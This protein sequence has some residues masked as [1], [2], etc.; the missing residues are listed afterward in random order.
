ML[1]RAPLICGSNA[2][3]ELC[4]CVDRLLL[5]PKA[6]V[7]LCGEIFCR[8]LAEAAAHGKQKVATRPETV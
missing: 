3:V 5:L 8:A 2:C 6:S 1:K 4:D 7:I